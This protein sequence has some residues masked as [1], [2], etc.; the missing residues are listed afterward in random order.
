MRSVLPK[1]S[2]S[3]RLIKKNI[4]DELR[5]TTFTR[6]ESLGQSA[7]QI[8]NVGRT[9]GRRGFR[10]IAHRRLRKY[11]CPWLR[12]TGICRAPPRQLGLSLAAQFA[13]PVPKGVDP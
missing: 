1:G 11:L 8:R 13:V 5:T 4:K 2:P 12:P 3:K 6:K 10:D 9:L 7:Y